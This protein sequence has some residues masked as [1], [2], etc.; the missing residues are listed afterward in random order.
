MLTL[1][2]MHPKQEALYGVLNIVNKDISVLTFCP[3]ISKQKSF[4]FLFSLDG[5]L[6][7]TFYRRPYFLKSKLQCALLEDLGL[8]T[9][10]LIG[11]F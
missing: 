9:C 10:E 6:F 7:P 4:R 3:P 1:E 8:L 5:S 11:N 2:V